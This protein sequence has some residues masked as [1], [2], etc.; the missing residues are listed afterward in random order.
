[1][2]Y[3]RYCEGVFFYSNISATVSKG[4]FGYVYTCIYVYINVYMCIFVTCHTY[5]RPCTSEKLRTF[6]SLEKI[7]ATRFPLPLFPI[8]FIYDRVYRRLPPQPANDLTPINHCA[9]T[10]CPDSHRSS[11][12]HRSW[13]GHI[14]VKKN[15]CVRRRTVGAKNEIKNGLF[16]L[17]SNQGYYRRVLFLFCVKLL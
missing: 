17:P 5:P 10:I 7:R 2:D 1:M 15:H 6:V 11:C 14:G 13:L 12:V 9:K 4:T 16:V 3:I 8:I